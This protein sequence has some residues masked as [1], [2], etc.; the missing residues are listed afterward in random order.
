MSLYK[1]TLES[2]RKNKDLRL[3]GKFTSI[4]FILLPE[5]S[6][7]IPGVEQEKYYIVTAN[8]KVGKTKLA[9]FLFLYN[10]Y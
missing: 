9:D 6:K 1:N 8:S 3:S 4:P 10:P 7:V 2:L 5:L